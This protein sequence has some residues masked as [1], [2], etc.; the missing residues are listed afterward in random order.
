M[1][2]S[3]NQE[4]DRVWAM[5]QGARDYITKPVNAD[6]LLGKISAL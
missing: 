3:K 5:R 1:C 2:T 4:T 6:E